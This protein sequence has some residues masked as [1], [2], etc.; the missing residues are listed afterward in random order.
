MT[1]LVATL[2]KDAK[3]TLNAQF[4]DARLLKKN[5]VLNN[6]EIGLLNESVANLA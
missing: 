4:S 1:L 5:L 6:L 3:V 2:P